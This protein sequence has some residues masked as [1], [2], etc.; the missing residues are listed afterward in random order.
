MLN[1]SKIRELRLNKG[2]T[3]SDLSNLSKH[4]SVQVSKSYLEEL[5]RG[6]KENPS[7]NIIETIAIIL[8]VNIDELRAS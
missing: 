4:L 3:C 1:G 8:C 5:E 7:F 2:M 6:T